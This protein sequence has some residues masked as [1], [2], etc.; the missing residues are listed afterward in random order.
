VADAWQ[1]VTHKSRAHFAVIVQ[2]ESMTSAEP[3]ARARFEAKVQRLLGRRIQSVDYWDIHNFG[4]EPARWDYGEW[5][6]AV[7]GVQL[8]T[9]ADPVTVTWTNTFHPYGVEVC[10][11]PIERHLVLNEAGPQ[12]N[13]PDGASRWTP[14]PGH[15][16]AACND[17]VGPTRARPRDAVERGGR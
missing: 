17:V 10:D 7:M 3:D 15:A 9:D 11:D 8:S 2:G 5:H 12:R 1:E 16:G 13:G 4:S 14:F 6:H